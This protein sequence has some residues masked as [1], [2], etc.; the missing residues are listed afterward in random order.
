[1]L[2]VEGECLMWDLKVVEIFTA[3]L[4]SPHIF[5]R[6]CESYYDFLVRE[7]LMFCF[8]SLPIELFKDVMEL[9]PSMTHPNI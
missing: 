1:V 7:L 4:S 9:L 6:V 8:A 2:G 3:A 5:I